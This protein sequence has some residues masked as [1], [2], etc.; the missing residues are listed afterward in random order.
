MKSDEIIS[1][2]DERIDR[3]N[4][5]YQ[6]DFNSIKIKRMKTRW[7]SCSVR[8]N[9]NFNIRIFELPS[10]LMDYIIVHELCHLRELNHSPRFWSLVAQV[11]PNYKSLKLELR[12]NYRRGR[13]KV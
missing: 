9:L 1:I 4:R 5:H 12:N 6:F 2:I 3:Y 11:I 8:K 10:R 13:I 7:G